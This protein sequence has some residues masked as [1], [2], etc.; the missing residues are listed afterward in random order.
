MKIP[1]GNLKKEYA[2]IAHEI[3]T[4]TKRVYKSGWFILGPEVEAF[5]KEFARYNKANHC[6]GVANG[7]EAIQ[8]ALLSAGVGPGDEVITT[9]LT[10]AATSLAIENIGAKPVFADIDPETFNLDTEELEKKIT[11]KTRAILPV[12]LYGQ[13]A[14]MRALTKLARKHKLLVIE[15]AAQAHGARQ[16]KKF[17]GTYGDVGAFSFY[18]SKNLGCYGDG[19]AIV[20]NNKRI[21]EKARR[22]R[23]YGQRAR[24]EHVEYGLNSRLDELQAAILRVKLKHLTTWTKR[25]KEIA[26]YYSEH[27]AETPLTLPATQERGMHAWHLYVVQTSKRKAFM[28]YLEKH[29][30]AS[31]IHYPKVLYHQGAFK[32]NRPKKK[33]THAERAVKNIVSLPIY[34]QMMD[35]EVR[36]VVKAIKGYYGL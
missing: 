12:H 34:P 26:A 9:P 17:A 22:I 29:G 5:E 14:D 21:A 6:I 13:M 28:S 3:D 1:L 10:A 16:D 36:K 25:R 18:P 23:D 30:V 11:K 2:G 24:Y 33:C 19:G 8:I 27:L 35:G 7:L 32:K 31:A 20:T 4:A 15:D